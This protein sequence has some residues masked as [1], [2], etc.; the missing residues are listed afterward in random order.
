MSRGI[1]DYLGLQHVTD[2]ASGHH[3]YLWW[4]E[5]HLAP[6][7]DKPIVLLEM[8]VGDGRSL[9]MWRDYF[10][11]GH[12]VG[13]D[14]ED[15]SRIADH[16]I[17]IVRGDQSDPS[18]LDLALRAAPDPMVIND[19]AGHVP[20]HQMFAF[21]HLFR[22]LLPGGVY[23]L[24]D[25]TS[26]KVINFMATL[27]LKIVRGDWNYH[28]DVW[29]QRYGQKIDSIGFYEQAVAVRRKG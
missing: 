11:L 17:S 10:A 13:M 23:L 16:R 7:R 14:I 8:G 29:A 5:T 4:Y 2:K 21:K 3:N 9:R 25:I 28:P 12:I 15:K 22:H 1:L 26:E 19:D 24:E 6:M 20:E 27:A 18:D